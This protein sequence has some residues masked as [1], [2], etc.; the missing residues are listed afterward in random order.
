MKITLTGS[1]GLIGS[2]L[3]ASLEE[4]GHQVV[5]LTRGASSAG[6][7]SWDPQG[8]SVDL[9]ALD[10][11][12]GL[13]HLAGAGIAQR[14]WTQRRKDLIKQSRI[15]GTACL[16]NGIRKVNERPKAFLSGSAIGYYGDRKDEILDEG[17]EHGG[18]FLAHLCDEWEHEARVAEALGVRTVLLRT[19][20]VLSTNGGILAKQL[21]IFRAGLGGRLGSGSQ[22]MSWI[23]LEDEVGIIRHLLEHPDVEGP[24]NLTSPN[25][26]T[27]GEFTRTLAR[28]VRRPALM[29]VPRFVLSAAMGPEAVAEFL[30]AGQRAFPVVAQRSGYRFRQPRLDSALATALAQ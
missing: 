6:S 25:P 15:A 10:G 11:V 2:A 12:D 3:A 18:G 7:L 1:H 14:R 16:V 5:R 26:V 29:T 28:A 24:A 22:W 21:P 19:G 27:N 17:F 20:I 23:S 8:G 4:D 30:L 9:A 13:V